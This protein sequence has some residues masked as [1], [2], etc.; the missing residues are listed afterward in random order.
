MSLS[1]NAHTRCFIHYTVTMAGN[2]CF[3]NPQFYILQMCNRRPQ[4][5]VTDVTIAGTA[6]W[7]RA[8]T[9][10][11]LY[12]AYCLLIV[13]PRSVTASIIRLQ[14]KTIRG[15]SIKNKFVLKCRYKKNVFVRLSQAVFLHWKVKR[16][17][18]SFYLHRAGSFTLLAFRL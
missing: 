8:L 3:R 6:T 2:W 7:W 5:L 12:I 16:S 18:V 10:S 13:S 4:H 17:P 1:S 11:F 14:K 15:V 9:L